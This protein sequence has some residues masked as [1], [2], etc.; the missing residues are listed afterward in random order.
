MDWLL[1]WR[2]ELWNNQ[3]W[4]YRISVLDNIHLYHH[5]R[6][7][8]CNGHARRCFQ[9]GIRQN[10]LHLVCRNLL[11]LHL[12]PYHSFNAYVIWKIVRMWR[13]IEWKSTKKARRRLRE[14]MHVWKIACIRR[15]DWGGGGRGR[16]WARHVWV[17]TFRLWS[18]NLLNWA[19]RACWV[20][21][22]RRRNQNL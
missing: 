3:L 19:P 22:R 5:G 13:Q 2:A 1:N 18:Q 17:V 4:Q 6:L 14:Q 16:T 10:V 7:V 15:R 21:C 11:L 8:K 20:Y 9:W 12:K